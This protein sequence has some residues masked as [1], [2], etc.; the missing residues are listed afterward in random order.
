MFWADMLGSKYI[1]S[2]LEKWSKQHGG[3]FKPC[4]YM[5]EKAAKGA[6]LVR[7]FLFAALRKS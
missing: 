6:L 7:T 3:F 5:A 2:R 4:A 1:Y